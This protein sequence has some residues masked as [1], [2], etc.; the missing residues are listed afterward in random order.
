MSLGNRLKAVT[1][2]SDE[3]IASLVGGAP[4]AA[5]PSADPF[6]AVKERA[7]RALFDRL[8]T[9]MFDA[10][11]DEA[12]LLE[13]VSTEL[14]AVLET[15][16][17]ALTPDERQGLVEQLCADVLGHGP[18]DELLADESVTEIMVSGTSRIYVEREGRLEESD[19]RFLNNEHL[20][21]VIERIVSRV[22]RR[23][24]ESSP[25]VD[26]RLPDGSRV[27][28]I[29]PPLSVDGPAL[30]IRKF[31][32]KGLTVDDLI[33]RGSISREVADFLEGCVRGKLNILVS[34]GT[35]SGKTTLLNIVSSFI[36]EDER[37]VTIEDAVELRLRQ[38]HVVRLESRP[39]NIEGKGSISIRDLVRNSLRMRPDR[40]I[41]GEVRSGEALDMLQAMNTG[42]EGSLSTLHANTPRDAISRL[43]TMV[44]MSGI[45]L[46][47]RAIRE[48]IASALDLI[49]QIGR[50]RDGSRR[51]VKISEVNGLE[52]DII[53]L[54]DLFEF[55]AAAGVDADGM[56]LG[57]LEATGLR[58]QCGPRLADQGIIFPAT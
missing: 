56:F 16:A 11:L 44:L 23:V 35:G 17:A 57:Q 37:I 50:L 5:A 15:E 42:H 45:E 20:R 6:A 58:P 24:D 52:G 3:S 27:N 33:T 8:G 32:K 22:G 43:E 2:E 39:P 4:V 34:G 30:T 48:Q 49:V 1:P 29:I 53:T 28:A 10:E 55:D 12:E 31:A 54:T 40:I 19:I 21:R 7:Q 47:V 9:R 38:R 41:V 51:V 13:M 46:P 25:M 26:A 18:I 36:P 14:V